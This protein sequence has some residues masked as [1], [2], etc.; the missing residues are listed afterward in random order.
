M[1]CV[2]ELPGSGRSASRKSQK[3]SRLAEHLE[4]KSSREWHPPQF[5]SP[6]AG[7]PCPFRKWDSSRHVPPWKLLV[8]IVTAGDLAEGEQSM[9][10]APERGLLSRSPLRDVVESE[11][12]RIRDGR[13]TIQL[14]CPH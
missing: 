12:L 4:Q 6:F 3:I 1:R 2:R 5:L 10:I 11:K 9:C 14:A 8:M 13:R 7:P